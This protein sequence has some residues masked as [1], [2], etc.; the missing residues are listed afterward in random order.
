MRILHIFAYF[1]ECVFDKPSILKS[2]AKIGSLESMCEDIAETKPADSRRLIRAGIDDTEKAQK[3]LAGL[4]KN[5]ICEEHISYIVD[6]LEYACDPVSALTFIGE[7]FE[8]MQCANSA[9]KISDENNLGETCPVETADEP[10]TLKRLICVTGASERIGRMLISRPSYIKCLSEE[11]YKTCEWDFET[12]KKRFFALLKTKETAYEDEESGTF[13]VSTLE[14]AEAVETL[15]SE[16]FR[17]LIPICALDVTSSDPVSIQPKISEKL[18]DLASAT[19]AAALTIACAATEKSESCKFAIIGMGKLGARELNYISDVDLIYVVQSAEKPENTA[20]AASSAGADASNVANT[21]ARVRTSDSVRTIEIGTKIGSC[22]HKICQS[23]I[24]GINTPPLWEIDEAL[25]PEGKAG[26]LVRTVES[27]R[28]YYEKWAENW[29]FQALLK[30]RFIAGNEHIGSEYIKV[31]RKFVWTAAERPD[32]VLDCRNMRKRVEDNI[33]KAHKER[34]IKLGKGGLR[35]VEFA[36]QMLQLVHGRTDEKIRTSSTLESLKRLAEGGYVSREQAE[37]LG[38]D[39][40]FERVLEHRQQLWN[41]QRT[42]LFPESKTAGKI[43]PNIP[44]NPQLRRLA[45]A[46]NA[47]SDTLVEFYDSVRREIR[48]LHTDIYYR[49]MLGSISKMDAQTVSLSPEILEERFKSI[50]FMDSKA[51]IRHVQTLTR[52]IGRAAKI[53]RIIMPSFLQMI[54]RGQNPDMALLTLVRLEENFKDGSRYLG[55]LRDSPCAARRLAN[56]ISNSRYLGEALVKSVESVMWL[57]SDELLK[58]GEL[59]TLR[60]RCRANAVRFAGK[61]KEFATSIRSMRRQEIERIGLAWMSKA[62]ECRQAL[63]GMTNVYDAA[64]EAALEWSVNECM[65]DGQACV[66]SD[67]SAASA[68]H[69]SAASADFSASSASSEA[70]PSAEP[71]ALISVIAMGRYGGREINFCS[72]A[73]AIIVYR[74][75]KGADDRKAALFAKNVV[76]KMREILM[77][78]VTK[79]AKIELDLD[80]RPEGKSGPLARSLKSCAQY[81]ENWS[82]TWEKQ[83][84]LR[85]R[86]AAGDE[87]TAEE[88]FEKIANPL[89]YSQKPLTQTQIGEIRKLKVRMESERLPRGVQKS[90]HMKLGKGGLSDVEWTVQ[91]LQLLH[92]HECEDLKTTSTIYALEVLEKHGYV[93]SEDA[94]TLRCAWSLTTSARNANYLWSG[95]VSQSDIIPD[96]NADLGGIASCMHRPAH[97]GQE[98]A[99]ELMSA[100]RHCRKTTERLFYGN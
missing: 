4:Q 33:P 94:Q 58:P 7:L 41:L 21:A 92:A 44:E 31:T 97:S 20:A 54:S 25:R 51:A 72:D 99:D 91:L 13:R 100:M 43:S 76:E 61:P 26:P 50:G 34:E 10:Q 62:I 98:F 27:H 87:Q 32:F 53:N 82:Q 86:F 65:K 15:R 38:F 64:L 57:G 83:A 48:Q 37:R 67:S 93:S 5:G 9:E 80:L 16:Y 63:E 22:L 68:S 88:F 66:H 14:F 74:P 8:K 79:E 42:H 36:V 45:R 95:R 11:G 12:R 35:D 29:E 55:F 24:A 75:N 71:P 81:Y 6:C 40:S 70:D 2:R 23:A 19:L 46:F 1:A 85:A 60:N 89:R 69:V 3:I 18:S 90:R 49:P 78:P 96:N 84:L 39:Y 30:A 17:Q 56:V 52:G 73:D 77:S 47:R 59:K 28:H